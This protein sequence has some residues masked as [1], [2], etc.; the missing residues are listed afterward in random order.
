MWKKIHS[1]RDPRDTLYS[2]M[3]REFSLYFGRAGSFINSVL[4][5]YPKFFFGMMVS[6]MI[7]SCALSFTLFR[8]PD[9]VAVKTKPAA[10][11][12]VRDGFSEIMQATG[13]IRRTLQ[14]KHMV[15]SISSKKR[16]TP[17]D[18]TALDSA[19]SQLQ[20]INSPIK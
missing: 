3:R 14:L 13:K 1:N 16:L 6:L 15:D 2:E 5:G 18:S 10:I 17:P 8:H 7:L 12:P 20:R 19:L 4:N 9:K 11:N